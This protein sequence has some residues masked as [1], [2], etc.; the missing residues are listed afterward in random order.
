VGAGTVTAEG[1][2]ATI[3]SSRFGCG[4]VLRPARDVP[5][6]SWAPLGSQVEAVVTGLLVPGTTNAC[7]LEPS[8][9]DCAA[10]LEASLSGAEAVLGFAS[11]TVFTSVVAASGAVFAA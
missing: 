8:E 11:G 9:P 5:F 6:A 2:A 1:A 10:R 7:G 4:L 3:L